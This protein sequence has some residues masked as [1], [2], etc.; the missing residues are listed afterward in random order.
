MYEPKLTTIEPILA[1]DL[2]TGDQF[3]LTRHPFSVVY[4]YDYHTK[5]G[6][7]GHGIKP[8]GSIAYATPSHYDTVYKINEVKS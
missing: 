1:N 3:R 7:E 5:V 4:S 8:D 6:I 2:R